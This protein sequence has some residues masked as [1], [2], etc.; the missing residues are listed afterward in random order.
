MEV[1]RVHGIVHPF[2][3][4]GHKLMLLRSSGRAA[5]RKNC[6]R[7]RVS[8]QSAMSTFTE[9]EEVAEPPA[10]D[11]TFATS[12]ASKRRK[13]GRRMRP[14]DIPKNPPH[15][16]TP[17]HC[18]TTSRREQRQPSLR[19]HTRRILPS[20]KS[21]VGGICSTLVSIRSSP[22]LNSTTEPGLL[23]I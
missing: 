16:G 7:I 18:G 19:E 15:M 14:T 4:M 6:K 8:R 12:W 13:F 21:Q 10:P 5:R 9:Q 3:A 23:N 1:R 22:K 17:H 2:W 20:N 11:E